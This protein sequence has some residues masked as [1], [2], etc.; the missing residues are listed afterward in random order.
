MKSNRK[1]LLMSTIRSCSLRWTLLIPLIFAARLKGLY[2]SKTNSTSYKFNRY[3]HQY[4]T[5]E[6]S[7]RRRKTTIVITTAL[8]GGLGNQIHSFLSIIILAKKAGAT[9]LVPGTPMRMPKSSSSTLRP[10]Q[11]FW[12]IERLSEI[13]NV[14]T[15]MPNICQGKY[16]YFF[17]LRSKPSQLNLNLSSVSIYSLNEV[18]FHSQPSV[19]IMNMTKCA[20]KSLQQA[21]FCTFKISR[22]RSSFNRIVEKLKEIENFGETAPSNKHFTCIFIDGSGYNWKTNRSNDFFFSFLHYLEHSDQVKKISRRFVEQF[23]GEGKSLGVW[24]LRYDEHLC[25]KSSTHYNE[26]SRVCIRKELR[27]SEKSASWLP[28]ETVVNSIRDVLK[29]FGVDVLYIAFSPYVPLRTQDVLIRELGRFIRIMPNCRQFTH[30]HEEQNFMERELALKAKLFL[31]EY[32]SSWSGT[33]YYKRRTMKKQTKWCA[34][35]CHPYAAFEN[36]TVL[37]PPSSFYDGF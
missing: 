21:K 29:S 2:V 31:G 10:S 19:G 8:Q 11:N 3:L 1:S 26:D 17:F 27:V 14:T 28:V 16:E 37:N 24:H 30:N 22:R 25:P 5:R 9:L 13:V 36:V 33:M 12:N 18:C 7:E 6:F 4:N 23:A 15:S 35:L 34:G 32:G 20:L